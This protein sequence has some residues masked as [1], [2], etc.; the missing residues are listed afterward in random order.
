[1]GA[2]YFQNQVSWGSYNEWG[3]FERNC[4]VKWGVFF[5]RFCW[6]WD[7]LLENLEIKKKTLMMSTGTCGR[8]QKRCMPVIIFLKE[9]ILNTRFWI[10]YIL[11]Q[12]LFLETAF[13]C[14]SQYS[15]L[16]FVTHW[17]IIAANIFTQAPLP[18]PWKSS[19]GTVICS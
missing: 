14:F 11:V 13:G 6:L 17:P 15:F 7:F 9:R 10:V 3:F 18:L 19:C 4:I 5:A 8:I 16:F 12:S 1:M 2:Y